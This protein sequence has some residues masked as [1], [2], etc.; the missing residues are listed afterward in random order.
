[1]LLPEKKHYDTALTLE[2]ILVVRYGL[3]SSLG[4]VDNYRYKQSIIGSIVL[5]DDTDKSETEIGRIY[6]DRLLFAAGANGGWN[7]FEIFDTE[8]YLMDLGCLIWDFETDD[9]V[10]VA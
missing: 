5:L 4:P 2:Q 7:Q 3:E 1:M 9:F 6:I 10:T 8:Q